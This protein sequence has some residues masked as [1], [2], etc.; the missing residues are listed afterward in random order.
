MEC[1]RDSEVMKVIS[2]IITLSHLVSLANFFLETSDPIPCDGSN[3]GVSTSDMLLGVELLFWLTAILPT[4]T[5]SASRS[6][7]FRSN[8]LC[9]CIQKHIAICRLSHVY[10]SSILYMSF[11]ICQL[12]LI[13]PSYMKCI[14][15]LEVVFFP[16]CLVI[17]SD[18]LVRLP[19][20]HREDMT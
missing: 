11:N 7:S 6:S 12:C 16:L 10:S 17:Y 18:V 2:G 5:I 19:F 14:S 15:K 4:C 3:S 20:L 1:E 9:N 13:L 8:N